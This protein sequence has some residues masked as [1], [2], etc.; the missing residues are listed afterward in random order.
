[1]VDEVVAALRPEQAPEGSVFIDATVGGGGHSAHLLDAAD[2]VRVIG[3]DQD[4]DAV[5]A[6]KER[7][8]C[9][10][11]RATVA[12]GNFRRMGSVPEVRQAAGRG[13][14]GGVVSRQGVQGILMDLGVSSYQMDNSDRGF[15]FRAGTRLGMGMGMGGGA[16]GE[17]AADLLNNSSEKE[18]GRVFRQG[19]ERRWRAL[20]RVVVMRRC[21]RPFKTSDDLTAA[22]TRVFGR[23]P[24]V[25][26]QARVFQAVR[27]AVNDEL[28]ALAEGLDEALDL[29]A[30][31][32]RLVVL[33]YH[34]LEDRIVKRRFREWSASCVCPPNVL[35]CQCRGRPLGRTLTRKPLRPSAREVSAN[36]RARSARL[37]AWEKAV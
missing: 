11:E 9:H 21:T 27:I 30:A 10:S 33:S 19:E 28:A 6:A 4:P 1:M 34:S 18:L 8:G 36:R 35:V 17:P 2:G 23:T 32:G 7:L 37:R 13:G 16:G 15:S 22:I 14:R 25:K 12:R 24:S 26:E 29:L 5:S 3:I 20:A 31:R